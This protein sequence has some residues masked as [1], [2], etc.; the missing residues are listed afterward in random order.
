MDRGKR[1]AAVGHLQTRTPLGLLQIG[2]LT[3]LNKQLKVCVRLKAR[4]KPAEGPRTDRRGTADGPRMDSESP[5]WC[6]DGPGGARMLCPLGATLWSAAD[7]VCISSVQDLVV[8]QILLYLFQRHFVQNLQN[9]QNLS[10]QMVIY[11][12][13]EHA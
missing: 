9:L 1:S 5:R 12:N 10:W 11:L 2:L 4:G 3:T 8:G 7:A 6:A 13:S